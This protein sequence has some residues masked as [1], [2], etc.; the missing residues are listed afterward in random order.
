MA[1]TG[2]L[3][4]KPDSEYQAIQDALAK[5][6]MPDLRKIALFARDELDF[7]TKMKAFAK[8][9]DPVTKQKWEPLAKPRARDGATNPILQDHGQLKRSLTGEAYPDGSVIYGSRMVYARIHQEGGA[10]G[11]GKRSLI[12]ARPY[13]GVPHGFDRQILND[14]HIQGILGLK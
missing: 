12:P 3:K 2:I 8:E 14:P 13:L 6:S 10:A 7:I 9:Q 4:A 1:G 11:R 5:A